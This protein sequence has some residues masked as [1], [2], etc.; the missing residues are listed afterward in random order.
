MKSQQILIF[1]LLLVFACPLIARAESPVTEVL[2]DNG[3][4]V[5]VKEDHRAPVVV[6]QIWYKVGS[7]YE[8]DGI[9]GVSHTLE[10]MM[11][12]GTRKY[13]DDSFNRIIAE[14]GA[15]DN[16][17]T[18]RDFTA[19]YQ[20]I[21]SD[22]LAV[23][24]DLESD[25]MRNLVLRQ[26]DFDKEI[27]VVQE[28]RRWR[29]EDK[30]E[31]LL[32]EQLYV[33]AFDN[34]GYHHPIIGWME[35]LQALTLADQK[36]WYETYYSPNNA[37]LVVVGD[38][39]TD[40]VIQMA[41]DYFGKIK[42]FDH[43][44][45]KKRPE[46]PQRSTKIVQLRVKAEVPLLMMGYKVPV[47]NT[48]SE[49]WE[50]YALDLLAAILDGGDSTRLPRKLVKE[51]EIAASVSTAYS[52][53]DRMQ[54]LFQFSAI[55]ASGVEIETIKQAIMDEIQ[56]VKDELV[57]EAELQ[58]IKNQVLASAEFEK[59]SLYYQAYK[60]GQA[61]AVGI[62]WRQEYDYTNR[63]NAIT[64]EQI[65]QVA[66]K[67]LQPQRLTIAILQPQQAATETNARSE[68]E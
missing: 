66:R 13:P 25:R 10:H 45:N 59:D 4:K 49:K 44:P 35:D 63:L 48:A 20:T 37:I 1:L 14:N 31:A 21:A 54:T 34:S 36:K 30:P 41:R 61:E 47:I 5:I 46:R 28:E 58:R 43:I 65:Q 27:M 7:S 9:T 42:P 62:G 67:Y 12:K 56:L 2:L 15:Q 60:I 26:K 51:R 53:S 6:S 22:R 3:L 38:V 55:P 29:T 40:K 11:F 33:T 32:Y 39:Q 18:S 64:R 57:S 50:P 23:S 52:S 19:Y 8:W 16:A 68:K 24:F 17:F